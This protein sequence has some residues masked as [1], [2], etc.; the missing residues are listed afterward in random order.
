MGVGS[1]NLLTTS[2]WRSTPESYLT[3]NSQLSRCQDFVFSLA[4][5]EMRNV[6]GKHSGLPSLLRCSVFTGQETTPA[7]HIVALGLLSSIFAATVAHSVV[8]ALIGATGMLHYEITNVD[9]D[10]AYS[11]GRT[12]M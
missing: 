2:P 5:M 7:S 12:V 3:L 4:T 1:F 8:T 9:T 11:A 6:T 10:S